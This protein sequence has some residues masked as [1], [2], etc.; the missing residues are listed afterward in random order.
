MWF[1][2][3]VGELS[4]A[5]RSGSDAERGGRVRRRAGLAGDAGQHRRRRSGRGRAG[6]VRR[7]LSR[8][9]DAVPACATRRR[10]RESRTDA[11]EDRARTGRKRQSLLLLLLLAR[12]PLPLRGRGAAAHRRRPHRA[13]A[14][15]KD[16]GTFAQ[17]RLGARA[18]DAQGR[19]R[20]C[21]R[22]RASV[23]SS[24][25]P[26][27]KPCPIATTA[28][29]PAIAANSEQLVF[30]YVRPGSAGGTFTVTLQKTDGQDVQTMAASSAI[31]AN[32][33][34][35]SRTARRAVSDGRLALPG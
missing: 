26:T 12:C 29:V 33:E 21:A 24:R 3:E 2:E 25:P 11:G 32:Q 4:A 10:N 18:G 6:Q 35:S 7:R 30:A 9:S 14:A 1:M 22:R 5:L 16:A 27:A 23:S 28:P 13:A 8:L 20:R 15:G 19:R 17:R 31:R 34:R